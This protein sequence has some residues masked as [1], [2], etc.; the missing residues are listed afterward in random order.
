VTQRSFRSGVRT[1]L[2][3]SAFAT[4]ASIPAFVVSALISFA[5]TGEIWYGDGVQRAGI[6]DEL[7]AWVAPW[8]LGGLLPAMIVGAAIGAV[9]GRGARAGPAYALNIT[10]ADWAVDRCAASCDREYDAKDIVTTG[11]R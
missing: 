5:R 4:L 3:A 1:A 11:S 6:I 8:T 2:W 10:E 7:A 9:L